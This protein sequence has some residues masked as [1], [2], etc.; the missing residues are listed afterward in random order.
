MTTAAAD[1]PSRERADGVFERLLPR[2]VDDAYR[3]RRLAIWLLVGVVLTRLAMGANSIVNTIPLSSYD[4]AAAHA[5]IG[6][7]AC[8]ACPICWS[9]CR[10]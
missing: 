9:P 1:R 10:R 8:L 5:V 7:F 4:P 6:L 2:Q 3:G